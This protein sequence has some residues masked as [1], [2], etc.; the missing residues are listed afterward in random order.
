MV[1]NTA[2]INVNGSLPV[3][4]ESFEGKEEIVQQRFDVTML[5][6]RRFVLTA[7]YN[8]S[9]EREE[10]IAYPKNVSPE[11]WERQWF[12]AMHSTLIGKEKKEIALLDDLQQQLKSA[13]LGLE[14]FSTGSNLG[15]GGKAV[16]ESIQG[17]FNE[18][19]K[20]K[21]AIKIQME[22]VHRARKI[23][24]NHPASEKLKEELRGGAL[25]EALKKKFSEQDPY[26]KKRLIEAI[27][28]HIFKYKKQK[29]EEREKRKKDGI[30]NE[31]LS[32]AGA[33]LEAFQKEEIAESGLRDLIDV[34]MN[35][36]VLQN[37]K[38]GDL[39]SEED[40]RE[41][42]ILFF[43]TDRDLANFESGEGKVELREWW[44]DRSE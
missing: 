3:E 31:Q 5:G 14:N 26:R 17:R 33:G 36:F 24:D 12:R 4:E 19:L 25:Q 32:V 10:K 35:D 27:D 7:L 2:E 11:E 40:Q 28:N 22:V 30:R 39:I 15:S 13:A 23:A 8:F 44:Y 21:P 34:V 38:K 1:E 41:D 9:Q 20:L 16:I 6:V 29:V 43:K 42:E 37:E 18:I